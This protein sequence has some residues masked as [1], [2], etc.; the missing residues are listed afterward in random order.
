MSRRLFRNRWY[1]TYFELMDAFAASRCPL[2]VVLYGSERK[3]IHDL[4]TIAEQNKATVAVGALCTVHK[5]RLEEIAV[6]RPG[7]LKM[8]KIGVRG[9]LLALGH[10]RKNFKTEWRK[11]FQPFGAGCPLCGELSSRERTLCLTLIR[12]LSDTEF[13]KGFSRAR[14]LCSDHLEK[15]L[16]LE[17]Q[18]VEFERLLND[19][20]GKLN[21]LLN[22]LVRYE[23]TGT[24][25]EYKTAAL[26]WFVD[27]PWPPLNGG[28]ADAT[29][30]QPEIA[31]DE[32]PQAAVELGTSASPESEQLLFENEKLRR[33]VRDLMDRLNELE[34]R[35]AA[36]HYRVAKLSDDNKRLEMGYTGANTQADGLKQ[37][38]RDLRQEMANIKNGSTE[39]KTKTSTTGGRGEKHGSEN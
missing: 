3:L 15:C 1:R 25:E 8:L 14:L 13:W 16:S 26:N 17:R 19:Q 27:R 20:S 30:T 22:E 23:A 35:A 32:T 11:W 39:A 37:L 2:C 21:A 36:L 5:V 33:Q 29:S 7:L 38:V 4:V 24:Q 18:G 28:E 9:S 6:D 31:L 12:C 10:P 34:S